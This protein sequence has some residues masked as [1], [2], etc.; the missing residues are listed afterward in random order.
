MWASI[1]LCGPKFDMYSRYFKIPKNI[2]FITIISY[3]AI[4]KLLQIVIY[5]TPIKNTKNYEN[6][7]GPFCDHCTTIVCL[8]PIKIKC[9]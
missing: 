6:H 5:L 3:V 7:I 4:D 2:G 8:T 1:C 9:R